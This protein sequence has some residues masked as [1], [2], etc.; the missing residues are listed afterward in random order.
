[1]KDVSPST[2]LMHIKN[3][4]K[5]FQKE[6]DVTTRVLQK[7][8]R[9]NWQES[10]HAVDDVSLQIKP[11]EVVGLAGESGCGKST[12]GRIAAGLLSPTSGQIL[13]DG[14]KLT[15]Q[16]T[17]RRE[18]KGLQIQMI[19]QNPF[20]SLNPRLRIR[21]IIGEAPLYHGIV[22]KK[23]LNGYVDD[24]MARCGLDP[25][26]KDRFPHQFSGG[27]RQ[28]IAICR[29][30]AVK[31]MFLVC[32][33]VVSALDASIQ[34]QIINLFN[35]LQR[36]LELTSIFIS[37]DMGV[38]EHISDR[39]VIMYLGRIV[40]IEDTDALF[41][42]PG[43]P[44]T[45]ALID[46]VPRLDRRHFDFQPV[47]GEIPSPLCPPTGCHFHPRCSNRRPD[48]S[49]RRPELRQIDSRHWV[50]CHLYD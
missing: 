12:L 24:L 15:G 45:K 31:P 42:T 38:V 26:Y 14:Q 5:I 20:A 16:K 46:Q 6:L 50:A 35:D 8:I 32:D 3:V 43:H 11:G 49:Q 9:K 1:M 27:Q 34:A 23:E 19:F 41:K 4:T 39:V 10:V 25:S 47:T 48:C 28:R 36:E 21:E 30:L 40:E 13:F 7:I 37:H 18:T 33:E 2:A 29:A 44:Y 17:C 22:T